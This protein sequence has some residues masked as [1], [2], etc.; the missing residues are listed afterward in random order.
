MTGKFASVVY[1]SVSV[2]FHSY[3]DRLGSVVCKQPELDPCSQVHC[4]VLIVSHLSVDK[5]EPNVC[6]VACVMLQQ[7]SNAHYDCALEGRLHMWRHA[8]G[9]AQ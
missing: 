6:S 3:D 4:L 1:I 7:V 2:A 8:C 5:A 9:F